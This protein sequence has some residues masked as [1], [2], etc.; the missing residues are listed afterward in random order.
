M[1]EELARKVAGKV[2]GLVCED[3][4][5]YVASQRHESEFVEYWRQRGLHAMIPIVTTT[6]PAR[7]IALL[8]HPES[9]ALC[10]KMIGLSVSE[11]PESPINKS[12]ELY[13][14]SRRINGIIVPGR[15]QHTALAVDSKIDINKVRKEI[16]QLGLQFMTPILS[17]EEQ[18]GAFLK[19]MFIACKRPYGQFVEVIQRGIGRSG[20]PFRGFHSSQI[21]ALYEHYNEY[22]K[23]LLKR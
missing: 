18:T 19:Q 7:H 2:K 22:S 13:G 17:Y 12:V 9:P 5:T 1:I 20:E 21:D 23:R 4:R 11:D 6:Y 14:G 3:H 8:E 10:E 16:Q 15:L